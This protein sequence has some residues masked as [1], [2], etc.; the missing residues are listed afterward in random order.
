MVKVSLG[1]FVNNDEARIYAIQ[2]ASDYIDRV[3]KVSDNT[4]NSND[5]WVFLLDGYLDRAVMTTLPTMTADNFYVSQDP[6]AQQMVNL[7]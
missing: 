5:R 2:S 7:I 3:F 6:Q 1:Y 4:N